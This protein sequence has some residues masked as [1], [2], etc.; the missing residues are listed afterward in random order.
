MI[1]INVISYSELLAEGILK[2]KIKNQIFHFIYSFA[3]YYLLH[4]LLNIITTLALFMSIN[5]LSGF[6]DVQSGHQT[7]TRPC[8]GRVSLRCSAGD[9]TVGF[10]C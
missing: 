5:T 1:L 3:I 8:M 9:A 4:T 7:Q 6:S 10:G 2:K